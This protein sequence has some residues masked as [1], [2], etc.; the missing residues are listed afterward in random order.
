MLMRGHFRVGDLDGFGIVVFVEAALHIEPC[1][2][3]VVAPISW[4]MT[5]WLISGL[6][7]QFW[8]MKAKSRCSMRFHLLVPG[9]WWATVMDRS[10]FVGE[11]LQFALPQANASAVA[12]TA[13]GGDQEAGRA[14]IAAFPQGAPPA[15][16]ALD[17]EGCGIVIDTDIDPAR[18]GRDVVDAVGRDL[19][20]FGYLEVV[21]AHR[22]G[23]A[24]GPQLAATILEVADQLLLLR[25]DRDRRLAGALELL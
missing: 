22:L 18:V 16:D 24:F 12:A 8:V 21:H 19:A 17:G 6:P 3:C 23:I 13:I 1:A 14:G 4:T 11:G 20:E 7:R 2:P 5:S 10:G 15:P 25:I 9:G